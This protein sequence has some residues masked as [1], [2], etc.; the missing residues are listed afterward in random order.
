M[1]LTHINAS[2]QQGSSSNLYYPISV[3]EPLNDHMPNTL[4]RV[5]IWSNLTKNCKLF[6]LNKKITNIH[7][8]CFIKRKQ[9]TNNIYNKIMTKQPIII[10]NKKILPKM[11]NWYKKDNGSWIHKDEPRL[12]RGNALKTYKKTL[13]LT[14][15]QKEIL[16][17]SLLGDGFIDFH[18]TTKQPTYLFCLAQT[19][20]AADYVDHIYQ[21][22]KPFAGAPPKINLIGGIKP[23]LAKRYE[24]RFKTYSHDEFKFY[25]DLFYPKVKDSY[26]R[27]KR[28]PKNIGELLT[29]ESLAYWYMDDGTRGAKIGKNP[30]YSISTHSFSYD[31]QLILVDALEKNFGILT[32]LHKDKTYF[33]LS[34]KKNSHSVFREL[35]EPFIHPYFEYKL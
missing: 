3:A 33:K 9:R 20:Y 28:V 29:A 17:G 12:L 16:V 6:K 26:K 22:F 11:A 7:N 18:R 13:I 14:Q 31:D 5:I 10:Q 35:I 1:Q 30:S 32:T 34:I 19:W 23:G 4:F 24:V 21:I 27:I 15:E 25:Y 2:N 8:L